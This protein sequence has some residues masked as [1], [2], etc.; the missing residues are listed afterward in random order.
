MKTNPNKLSIIT[1]AC[2]EIDKSVTMYDIVNRYYTGQIKNRFINCI[3]HNDKNASMY[4]N[5]PG[6]KSN[7]A[8][9]YS[10]GTTI[11]PVDFVCKYYGYSKS[12]AIKLIISD[13]GLNI[14]YDEFSE[15]DLENIRKKNI[16]YK[17]I[18][19][20]ELYIKEIELK[21]DLIFRKLREYLYEKQSIKMSEEYQHHLYLFNI[22]SKI[23]TYL[24][25]QDNI[26][27]KY[28]YIQLVED[29]IKTNRINKNW[30]EIKNNF[31]FQK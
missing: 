15:Y 4:I 30:Y 18:K 14:P 11:D 8:H 28:N 22:Y 20:M 31:E 3:V 21:Y 25:K 26:T 10:C 29:G 6:K 23:C 2:K 13:F 5:K 24:Y 7:L 12:E 9:C 16:E 1:N 27:K 19:D 17:K